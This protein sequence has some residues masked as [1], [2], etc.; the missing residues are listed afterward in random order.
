MRFFK[1]KTHYG[2]SSDSPYW[3]KAGFNEYGETWVN[4]RGGWCL[5]HEED[6]ILEEVDMEEDDFIDLKRKEIYSYLLKSDS[7]LG[8][9]A[10]DGTFYG[11]DYA[12]HSDV[13]VFYFNKDDLELE[14]AGWIK[15][16][17]SVESGE[18]IYSQ[19][20]VST[21]QRIWLE[22]HAVKYGYC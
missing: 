10:P 18:P 21:P 15:V 3:V 8:W 22:D 4:M 16:F 9:L 19:S 7:D 20:R 14:K 13:A 6:E 12:S 5:K 1:I 11:C 17:R 2:N